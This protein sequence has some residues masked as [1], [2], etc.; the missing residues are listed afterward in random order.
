MMTVV[1][2]SD[3]ENNVNDRRNSKVAVVDQILVDNDKLHVK[4]C[5]AAEDLD[6]SMTGI[7]YRYIHINL[8]LILCI[9]RF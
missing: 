8:L 2:Q 7:K 6:K 5:N 9:C 3:N 1:G 4:L